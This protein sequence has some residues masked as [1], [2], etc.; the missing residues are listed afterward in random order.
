MLQS[1]SDG[2]HDAPEEHHSVLELIRGMNEPNNNGGVDA[3]R[4]LEGVDF[5]EV[6]GVDLDGVDTFFVASR[7]SEIVRYPCSECHTVPLATMSSPD[8]NL[9]RAHWEVE[10]DHAVE[11]VMDCQTCHAP[12]NTDSLVT[13]GGH[14]VS[15]DAA[16][17]ICGQ[18][19][20]SQLKEWVWGAHGKRVGGWAPP[21]VS[22]NCTSCHN[23]HD[24][25]FDSRFPAR[26]SRVRVK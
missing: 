7:T 9:K 19:H 22:N 15:F 8:T 1:C 23:P 3:H 14:A 25:G 13:L 20:S 2:E 17:R 10:L 16:Y 11:G 18:C 5:S 24:P 6:E 26:A 4:W 12:N 21:R